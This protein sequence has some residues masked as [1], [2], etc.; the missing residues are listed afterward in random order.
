MLYTPTLYLCL[1]LASQG[2]AWM[3]APGITQPGARTKT[4][5]SW[6]QA[7]PGDTCDSIVA[8]NEQISTVATFLDLNPQLKGECRSLLAYYW[9]CRRH[10]SWLPDM[11]G[12]IRFPGPH[13]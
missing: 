9:Y 2:L 6:I 11:P 3:S 5:G 12:T 7:M 8:A 13:R 10:S 4:C 1:A